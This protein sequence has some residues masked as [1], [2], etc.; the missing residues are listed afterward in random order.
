MVC[1]LYL[2]AAMLPISRAFHAAFVR[3]PV[4]SDSWRGCAVM[5]CTWRPKL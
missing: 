1:L 2:T 3:N 4:D 5:E